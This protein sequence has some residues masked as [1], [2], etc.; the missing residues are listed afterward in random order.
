[1]TDQTVA[2]GE[3]TTA[4]VLTS[5]RWWAL[6]VLTAAQSCHHIDRNVVSV[7]VEPLRQEFHLTDGQVGLVGTFGYAVAFAIAALPI[8][9]LVDRINRRTMLA[10]ILALWSG[11]TALGGVANSFVH[12]LLARMG[13][14]AAEAGGSPTAMSILSDYFP[15]N[16]RSTALGVWYLASGIG[17]GLIFLVGGLI[18]STY[19]WRAVF[20]VAAVPGLIVAAVMLFTVREPK[21]GG[22]EAVRK[23]SAPVLPGDDRA[24]T[25]PEAFRYV[26]RR[27]AMW[28][29]MIAIIITAAMSSA[30]GLWSVSF[31]VRIHHVPLKVAGMWIAVAF[32][33]FGTVIPLIAGIMGDRLASSKAVMKPERLALVSAF[34]MTGVVITGTTAAL[35]SSTPLAIAMML[36]WCGFMLGHNGPANALIVTLLRPRM[37]GVV[38]ATQQI[39][40][41]LVGAGLGPMLVGMLSDMYGGPDSLRWAIVTGMSVNVI[42]VGLFLLASTQAR[43]D[44]AKVG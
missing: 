32:A 34:T 37:R 4:A 22:A 7:V 26:V 14:G 39:V 5:H 1:M 12:L 42:A 8:G 17:T 27:P 41:S 31:L 43:K 18:A 3:T 6:A 29:T 30:F 19:G 28:C 2:E 38:V 15:P 25:L 35:T 10:L 40:A 23:A 20:Y 24:A 33:I 36:L 13:V 44:M 11:L 16:Q 21:R 9:Y